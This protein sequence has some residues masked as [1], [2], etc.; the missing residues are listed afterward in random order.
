MVRIDAFDTQ[1]WIRE[2]RTR[3]RGGLRRDAVQSGPAAD[4]RAGIAQAAHAA[5]ARLVVDNTFATPFCVKA[6]GPGA[7]VVV[8]SATKFLAGHS[9]VV[10]GAVTTDDAGLHEEIQRR[11][12]TFGG[13]TDPHAAFLLWRGCGRS[14]Y[15]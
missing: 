2:I 14:G 13:C 11:L 5:G 8:E 4:G 10:V 9:D 15:G 6:A 3:R 7:D 12:I 1:A